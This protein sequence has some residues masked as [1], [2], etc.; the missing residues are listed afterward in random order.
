MDNASFAIT[1]LY[2]NAGHFPWPVLSHGDSVSV[3][4]QPGVPVGMMP[5][6]QYEQHRILLGASTCLSV[7]SDGVLGVL[8]QSTLSAKLAYLREFFGKPD[9]SIERARE[10]LHL[11]DESP[12]PDDV[13]ILIVRRGTSDGNHASP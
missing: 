4:E 5:K 2:A 6:T 3:L 8:P 11:N 12:L 10:T 9:I 7:F 13:A 1:Q